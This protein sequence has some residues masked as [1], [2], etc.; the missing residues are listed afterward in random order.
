MKNILIKRKDEL[1]V[2][3]FNWGKLI[4]YG[5]KSMKNSE[6]ITIGKCIL[7]P[8]QSNPLHFHPDCYEILIVEKGKILHI[9]KDG[10][11][12]LL[13][14]G[15][16]ITIPANLPHRAKN[17]TEE[18]AVLTVCFSTGDRKSIEI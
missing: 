3:E 15:D 10:N 18:E 2:V 11:G 1:E 12:V 9:E 4:W 6:D 8:Y 5:N 7:N 16:V 13:Q 17:L 14:E